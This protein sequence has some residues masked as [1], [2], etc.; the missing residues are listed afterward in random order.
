M[1]WKKVKLKQFL[2]QYRI[3]HIVQNDIEYK[4]VTISKYDGVT[5]RGTKMGKEIGR[6]RQFQIDLKKYPNTLMFVR[7][8]VQD[9]SIGIAPLEVDGC[10]A[11]ENMPMFSIEGINLEYLKFLLKSPYFNDELNKIQTTGSAQKSIHEREI[12]EIEI[13]FPDIE[14]QEEIVKELSSKK[15]N[16]IEIST[17]L[18]HQLTLV[19][20]LR[21][22]LLQDAVQGKLVEQNPKDEPASE[23]LKK[24]KADKEKLIAEK[25][26]KKEKELPPIKPEEIPFEI[27][28][29]WKWCRLGEICT[30]ITDGFHNTPPKVSEG[31]PYIAATQVKSDKIDWDNCNYVDE[32]YHRELYIKAYPQKG[33]LLVVNIG[34]GCG[35]PAL[36]DV[37]FEFSFKNTA[38]LK[39]N[40][41]LISN[42][43]LFYYFL[44]RKDEIYAELTKGGL[45]PFLSLKILNEI[46]FPLPPIAEQNRIV[47]KL[48][49]LMQYCNELE[50]SIKQSESQNEKLLQQVLREALRKEPVEEE[51]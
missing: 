28:E 22:Q 15:N 6:K 2:K 35:T 25:K 37:D 48:D 40:Q 10:I 3:E 11:T 8:G 39:F 19:K 20:K 41:N 4:Q 32:K 30:K 42:K 14:E 5:F 36:I 49:E 44:L 51:V 18:T 50:A 26:L 1:S 34:A 47:Q 16:S 33:E 24:I 29:N 7:Q 46:D 43:L 31:I 23:L 27:P 13:P 9:G 45:Q 38:I 12:L 21:Q 17:E